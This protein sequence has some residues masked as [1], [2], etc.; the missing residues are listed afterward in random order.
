M[1]F[2]NN[3]GFP[4]YQTQSGGTDIN[5]LTTATLDL[6]GDWSWFWDNTE[7]PYGDMQGLAEMPSLN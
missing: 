2:L 4:F 1:I 3:G 5:A 6:D 7:F